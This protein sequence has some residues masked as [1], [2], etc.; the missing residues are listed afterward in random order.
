MIIPLHNPTE[1]SMIK[2]GLTTFNSSLLYLFIYAESYEY[3]NIYF[4]NSTFEY[5]YMF[6]CISTENEILS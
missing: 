3:Y 6:E 2:S 4:K 1:G 5:I